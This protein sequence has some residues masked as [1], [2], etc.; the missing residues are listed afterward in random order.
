MALIV[1]YST[2]VHKILIGAARSF[3]FDVI[4]N[5]PTFL[6]KQ[7]ANSEPQNKY[8]ASITITTTTAVK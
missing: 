5:E 4:S 6:R 8:F 1:Y 3:A 2:W 7:F